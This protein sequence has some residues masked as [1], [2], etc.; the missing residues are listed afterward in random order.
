VLQAGEDKQ[1]YRDGRKVL[2]ETVDPIKEKGGEHYGILAYMLGIC[3]VKLDVGGDNIAQAT[4]WMGV[5]AQ[6]AN[7]YQG[8]AQN[9]LSAIKKATQ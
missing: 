7:P 9:T 2:L 3:Y 6:E 8:E 1:A 5:S 4:R